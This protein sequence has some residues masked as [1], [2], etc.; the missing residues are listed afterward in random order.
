VYHRIVC[1]TGKILVTPE[2]VCWTWIAHV[3]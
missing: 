2:I 1:V 3:S